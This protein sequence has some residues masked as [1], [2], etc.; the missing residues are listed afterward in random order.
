MT[1]NILLIA[2]ASVACYKAAEIVRRLR[3]RG[4]GAQV[5][6]SPNAEKLVGAATFR[7]LSGRPALVDEWRE[8]DSPDGMDHI[9]AARNADALLVAPAT[10]DFIAKAANGICE[11]LPLAAFAAA[12]IPKFIAPA[13]NSK[14]WQNPA[15]S[16]NVAQLA[17]DGVFFI[18]PDSG[19]QACGE[20]G[21]GRMTEPESIVSQ[22]LTKLG[23]NSPLSGKKIVVNA[24]ATVE[25]VDPMRVITNLSSGKMGFAVAEAIR[26]AGGDVVVVAAQTSASP[27][28]NIRIVRA[29]TG[30]E[31]RN[32]LLAETADADAFI[33]V[34]AV[35]DFRPKRAAVQKISRSRSARPDGEN[36][37]LELVPAPDILAEVAKSRPNLFC[38]GFAAETGNS[39][40]I[41]AAARRKMREKGVS[42]MVA[43]NAEDAGRDDCQLTIISGEGDESLP[44]QPKPVAAR[45]L[46][47]RIAARMMD[48]SRETGISEK[49][50]KRIKVV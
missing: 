38:V 45:T 32:A 17:Q 10:A 12:D 37:I 11:N 49:S 30:E 44:R 48:V 19:E 4:A 18:G 20:F 43:N 46:V 5:M 50:G 3:A 41:I 39:R 25:K 31:M 24:G 40:K 35:A 36:P 2:T 8:P 6:L 47:D 23:E 27:P 16:R 26:R 15:N 22:L 42:L 29:L 28:E 13:M 7:A 14:M 9:A 33:A 34:A 21:F 1:Q